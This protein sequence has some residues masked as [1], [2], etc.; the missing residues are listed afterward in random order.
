MSD[1]AVCRYMGWSYDDVLALPVAIYNVLI[2]EL[3]KAHDEK[4]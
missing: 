3:N 2:E 1:L 4:S